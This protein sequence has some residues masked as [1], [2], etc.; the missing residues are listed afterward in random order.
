MQ[1]IKKLNND[2]TIHGMIVL[3]PLDSDNEIDSDLVLDT[4]D[5]DKD[6]DGLVLFFFFLLRNIVCRICKVLQWKV[7]H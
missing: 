3:M 1:E 4:V 6:V 2:P 7:Y 5:A